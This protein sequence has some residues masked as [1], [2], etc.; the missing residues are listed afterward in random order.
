MF[1]LRA[2]EYLGEATEL[3]DETK[4]LRRRDIRWRRR[5]R[6]LT[7]YVGADEVQITIRASKTDQYREG[8]RRSLTLSGQTLCVVKA[9]QAVFRATPRVSDV[10]PLFSLQGHGMITRGFVSEVLKSAAK[11]LGYPTTGL[12]SHS[13]RGGGATALW[14]AGR[15]VEEICYL[16]RWK[17]DSWKIYTHMTS[18]SLA[19]IAA[20]IASATYTLAID[21]E[22]AHNIR[23]AGLASITLGPPM[24]SR[25]WDGE[26]GIEFVILNTYLSNTHQALVT[27]Y[28]SRTTWDS[29]PEMDRRPD[30]VD[31]ICDLV[32]R[33]QYMVYVSELGEVEG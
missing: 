25:W 17:S 26:E 24:G 20:D 12:S 31:H 5:G 16:G 9:L 3:W 32:L 1:L 19:G 27:Q 4:V 11:D 33:S 29:V 8:S 15:T 7:D 28:I 14:N 2:S 10:S 22:D 21:K 18:Q 13:L 23:N 6:Y 30:R